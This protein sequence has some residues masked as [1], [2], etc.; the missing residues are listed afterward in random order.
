MIGIQTL[1]Q[2]LGSFEFSGAS[3]VTEQMMI[4]GLGPL[5]DLRAELILKFGG[6][7]LTFEQLLSQDDHPAAA[8]RNYK[9][10]IL[11]LEMEGAV[12]VEIPGRERRKS[13]EKLTLPKDAVIT[14]KKLGRQNG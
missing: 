5:D 11:Q 3:Q 1:V 9:D 4:P 10:A 6:R 14:F 2:G 8:E 13:K 12:V 7:I